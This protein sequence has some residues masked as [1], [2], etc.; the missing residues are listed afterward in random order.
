MEVIANIDR[1]WMLWDSPIASNSPS[2]RTHGGTST[3]S[4]IVFIN[5]NSPELSLPLKEFID[6][7]ELIDFRYKL[8]KS[9]KVMITHDGHDTIGEI[10]ELGIY[11]FGNNQFEVLR[12][13]NKDVTELFE[14]LDNHEKDKLGTLPK[15]WKRF[16]AEYVE[17]GAC[18]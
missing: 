8:K 1:R 16:L 12:E 18:D 17:K 9:L 10:P 11:A 3:F 7:D 5:D 15:K 2:L 13:I 6:L 14:E 4:Q